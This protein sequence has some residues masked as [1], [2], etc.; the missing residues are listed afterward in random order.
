LAW[1]IEVS[2]PAAKQFEK[3]DKTTAARLRNFLRDRVARLDDPRQLGKALK[4]STLGEFWAYRAGDYRIICDLQ[5]N[6]LVVLVLAL[7]NRRDVY[8][9]R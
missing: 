9:S 2:P 8:R 1:A 6:R 3:L 5:D 7:S 4:G